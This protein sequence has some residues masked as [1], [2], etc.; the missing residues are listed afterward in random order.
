MKINFR[1]NP[2]CYLRRSANEGFTLVELLVAMGVFVILLGIIV[3]I[4]ISALRTQRSLAALM[5]V[6]DNTSLVLEQMAREIRTG[7]NFVVAP[8]SVAS[9][10]NRISSQTYTGGKELIFCNANEQIV[11]YKWESDSIS[12]SI[13]RRVGTDTP[14]PITG[15]NVKISNLKFI[16]AHCGLEGG[17]FAWPPRITITLSVTPKGSNL[18]DVIQTNIQTTVSGRNL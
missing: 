13:K 9:C 1:V 5:L 17:C 3:G 4:F 14:L 10:T 15:D 8:D 18:E 12:D 7:F 16:L 6:N 2:R 11:T